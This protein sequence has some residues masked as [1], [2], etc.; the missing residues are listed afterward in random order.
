MERA[1]S[2]ENGFNCLVGGV[3]ERV[4][5]GVLRMRE[6][7]TQ[8]LFVNLVATSAAPDRNPPETGDDLPVETDSYIDVVRYP[9]ALAG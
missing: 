9:P 8:P 1:P 4:K 2:K 7:A 3:A 5:Y 6:D